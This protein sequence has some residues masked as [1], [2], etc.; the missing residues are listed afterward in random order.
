[1][2]SHSHS[3]MTTEARLQRQLEHN[4]KLRE[5]FERNR[6]S[7][8]Q[9]SILLIQYCQTKRDMLIPTVW[10]DL[11]VKDDPFEAKTAGCGCSVM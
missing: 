1:M 4:R 6:I 3:P 10:G 9:A 11:D 2:N 5:Q 8:S 7:V